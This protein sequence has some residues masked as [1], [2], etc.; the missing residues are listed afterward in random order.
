MSPQ[1][2]GENLA[3]NPRKKTLKQTT[4]EKI[5]PY[6]KIYTFI[7]SPSPRPSGNLHKLC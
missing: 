7:S 2:Q 3:K 5:L 4:I 1:E 6:T